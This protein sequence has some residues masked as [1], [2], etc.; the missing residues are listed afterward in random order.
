MNTVVINQ[1]LW[2]DCC[3]YPLCKKLAIFVVPAYGKIR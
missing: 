3:E 1:A 2:A